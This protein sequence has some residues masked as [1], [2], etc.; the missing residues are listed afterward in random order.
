MMGQRKEADNK[1]RRAMVSAAISHH[2]VS[3]YYIS[4]NV[5]VLY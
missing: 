5:H 1:D 4:V 2:S 3:S